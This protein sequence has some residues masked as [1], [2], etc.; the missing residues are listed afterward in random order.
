MQPGNQLSGQLQGSS[1]SPSWLAALRAWLLTVAIADLLWEM[2]HLPLYTL[3]RSGTPGEKLFAVV[4]WTAGDLLIGLASLTC[5][6]TLAGH[7]DWPARWFVIVAVLTLTFGFN[8][9]VFSELLNVVVRKSW[10]YSELMPTVSVF[11]EKIGASPLLQWIVVPTLALY[12]SRHFGI[13]SA[14]APEAGTTIGEQQFQVSRKE[15]T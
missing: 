7:R 5:G 2:A 15:R 9:T 10:A 13:M 3:W 8:Y 6:L 12:V 4:H 11:G 1:T 14:S